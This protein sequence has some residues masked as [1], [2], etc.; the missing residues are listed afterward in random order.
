MED[1]FRL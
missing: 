1:P